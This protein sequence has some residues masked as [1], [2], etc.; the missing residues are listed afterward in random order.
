MAETYH[1]SRISGMKKKSDKRDFDFKSPLLPKF[2]VKLSGTWLEEDF[3][4]QKHTSVEKIMCCYTTNFLKYLNN[5]MDN[6][7]LQ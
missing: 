3:L 2:H 7:M 5:L 6:A 4:I 1:F